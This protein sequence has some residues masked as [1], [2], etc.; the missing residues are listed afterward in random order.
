MRV[1]IHPGGIGFGGGAAF[2]KADLDRWREAVADDRAGAALEAAL[3][4][5]RALPGAEIAG[6]ALKRVP[7]PYEA[8]HPRG[9]LLRHKM[10]QARWQEPVPTEFENAE[11]VD[12][13]LERLMR[14]EGLHH[15]LLANVAEGGSST[16]S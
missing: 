11:F 3:D 15:W 8:D 6:E 5:L 4:S 2:D 14:F 9:A 16:R 10:I 1:R 13:C 7:A 12:W